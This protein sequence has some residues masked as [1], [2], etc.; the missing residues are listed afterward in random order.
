M[1][2][3]CS[4]THLVI[5]GSRNSVGRCVGIGGGFKS[6]ILHLK[7]LATD[8]KWLSFSDGASSDDSIKN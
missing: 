2:R 8:R 1:Q 5:D 6:P 4:G 7:P 3:P